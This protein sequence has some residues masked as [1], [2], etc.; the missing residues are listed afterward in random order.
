MFEMGNLTKILQNL[1]T[2][3]KK[4]IKINFYKILF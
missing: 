2:L 4:V 3:L 1:I